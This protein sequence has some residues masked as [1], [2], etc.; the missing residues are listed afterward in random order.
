MEFQPRPAIDEDSNNDADDFVTEE[1]VNGTTNAA[2][3][4]NSTTE[5]DSGDDDGPTFSFEIQFS[6][7]S[8]DEDYN[9]EGSGDDYNYSDTT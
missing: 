2:T 9:E 5:A 7:G 1:P 4:A 3:V 8:D 6:F